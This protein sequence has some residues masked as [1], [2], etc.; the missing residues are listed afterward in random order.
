MGVAVKRL[1]IGRRRAPTSG[2]STPLERALAPALVDGRWQVPE[3]FNFARDV[4]QALAHD[5]KRRAMTFLGE[6]GIIEPRSFLQLSEGAARWASLLREREIKPGDRVLVLAD[7][8]VDWIEIMIGCLKIGAVSVPGSPSLQAAAIEVRFAASGASILVAD[9]R[10]ESAIAQMSFAPDVYYIGEGRRRRASDVPGDEPTHDTS[11]RDL[12]FILSTAGTASGPRGVAHTHGSAFA[13]RVQAE[14][15]LDAARGDAVWCTADTTSAQAAWNVLLGPWSCGAEI[16]LHDGEF[17]PLE[18]LELIHRLGAT[19]LCQTPAEYRALAELRELPRFR[20]QRLR[21]LA[22]TGDY[23]EPEV[24][25]VF[26]E[27]WGL[28]IHDG[29]GQAETGVVL[30]NG[31]DAGFKPGSIGLPL[32]G[33]QVAVVDEQ[34]SELPTGIEGDLALRGRPPTLFNAYWESP[35]ETKEAF[36]G[37][38]YLTGDVA[39]IDEDG[40]FWFVGRASD[41]IASRGRTFGPHEVERVLR[42]HEAVGESAVVGVR[43]LARGGHFVRAF[44]VLEPGVEGSEQL[45]AE[46]RTFVG[47]SLPE[48]QVPRE[49]EFLAELPKTAT[50]KVRRLDLRERPVAGRPLWEMPP[51]SEPEP[52][53]VAAVVAP[54]P[55]FAE[56]EPVVSVEATAAKPL[57]EPELE[58]EPMPVAPIPEPEPLPDYVVEPEPELSPVAEAAPVLPPEPDLVVIP[59]DEPLPD[60]IIDPEHTV[61]PVVEAVPEP[62]PEPEL[63]PLPD[64]IRDPDREPDSTPEVAAERELPPLRAPEHVSEPERPVVP[65]ADLGLPPVTDFP[66]ADDRSEPPKLRK[67]SRR[68]APASKAKPTRGHSAGEPGDEPEEEEVSWMQ[69]LSTRLSAYSLG[70]E[71]TPSTAKKDDSDPEDDGAGS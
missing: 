41:V 67:P 59:E 5:P 57:P 30:A 7:T 65:L 45:E 29:Y 9:H 27:A 17:D 70:E 44:V 11:S 31:A 2:P 47:Q 40:F 32:P 66:S 1:R 35:D 28:T 63:G 23:L 3:R 10:A 18:R 68:A 69:G 55:A 46:L 38:W 53:P 71:E 43:D 52:E 49:I 4:V 62:E 21:R 33:H 34:G 24:V 6:D 20:S 36:S 37:D 14:H 39:S 13:A 22:S 54:E 60:F 48:Q 8:N 25:A 51:T 56:P 50:G 19:I 61:E 64:Y 58:P 16:V 12:A 26:E 15:W 42:D